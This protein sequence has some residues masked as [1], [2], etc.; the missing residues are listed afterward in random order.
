VLTVV[1]DV[2]FDELMRLVRKHFS[3]LPRRP[4]PPEVVLAEPPQS[5]ER[6]SIVEFE[7]RP[8]LGMSFHIP[9]R[10]HA[11]EPALALMTAVLSGHGTSTT[12]ESGALTAPVAE[13]GSRL[14]RRLVQE[15]DLA[16][17]IALW[18]YPG[19][20]YAR[21]L[22]ILATPRAPH[23]LRELEEGITAELR[24]MADQAV[25]AAELERAR[26]NLRARCLR[27]LESNFGAAWLLGFTHGVTGD[28]G[29]LERT[30]QDLQRVIPE[31]VR[32]V[33]R[34]YL[35]DRNRT[36][37]WRVPPPEAP[38]EDGS[39]ADAAD[40]AGARLPRAAA[41]ARIR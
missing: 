18:G 41:R 8:G 26:R 10:S 27:Q 2:R 4:P 33:A 20:R 38:G 40:G 6:R 5:G 3:K 25:P 21:A 14:H 35:Q 9:G 19:D 23:D 30:M 16:Q 12:L 28:W 22:V 31:D 1:G 15:R 29:S 39:K 11:D 34:A 37:I 36:V 24:A 17:E 7:A 32:R 13:R